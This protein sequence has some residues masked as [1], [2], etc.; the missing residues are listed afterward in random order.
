MLVGL[1]QKHMTL[2]G[3]TC[4]SFPWNKA[5]DFRTPILCPNM[6]IYKIEDVC[7]GNAQAM[8]HQ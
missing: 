3:V 8:L 7:V 4:N 6:D 2:K 1:D 5:G